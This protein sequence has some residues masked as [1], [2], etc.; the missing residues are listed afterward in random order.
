MVKK[1]ALACTLS[2]L[3]VA[4]LLLVPFT[5]LLVPPDTVP[6]TITGAGAAQY[7]YNNLYAQNT[8]F[9]NHVLSY[10]LSKDVKDVATGD[11]NG[12]GITDVVVATGTQVIIY[13]GKEDGS[14]G[15]T[16][17]VPYTMSDIR[18][19]AVGDLDNDGR[20]DIAATYYDAASSLYRVGLFYQ[21]NG[22][23]STADQHPDT[24]YDPWQVLIGDFTNTGVNSLAVVCRGD[25]AKSELA[26][27][28]IIKSPFIGSTNQRFIE[29]PGLAN[30]KLLAA[31]HANTDGRLDL[32]A[33]DAYGSKVVVLTQPASF[34]GSWSITTV[35]LGGSIADIRFM[36]YSGSGS[37]KDLVVV[38]SGQSYDQVEV[39]VNDGSIPTS[40]S[41]TLTVSGA[42]TVAAGSVTGLSSP[43][44]VV[45]SNSENR[46]QFYPRQGSGLDPN[47]Y[48]KFPVNT[49][50]IKAVAVR[51]GIYVLSSGNSGVVEYYRYADSSM[52][53]ADGV[54]FTAD[55][56][57]TVV[58]AGNVSFGIIAATYD[59]QN[60]VYVSS[61]SGAGSRVITTPS[62]PTNLYIGDLDGDGIGDLAVAFRSSSTISIYRG[63]SNFMTNNDPVTIS[64]P[65]PL[66][67]PRSLTGGHIDDI[68]KDVLVVGCN[69]GIDVIYNPLSASPVH[70]IIGTSNTAA[71]IDVA[72]GRLSPTGASGGIAA[73][74]YSQD[75]IEIYYVK[76]SPTLGHC[77]DA[78]Y[79]AKLST[80]GTAS[81]SIAVG[82]FDGNGKDD[83][84]AALTTN[85][86]KIF[87]NVGFS[88]GT[89]AYTSIT[90]PSVASQ[91]R[92]A[93]LN[94][95]GK[96]DL[97]VS[98]SSQANIGIWLSRDSFS[99]S[100]RFNMTAG[101]IA[102]G[103]FVGDFNGDGRAD[104]L[105]SS[106][107]SSAISYWFQNDL[108]PAASAWL[109]STKVD[110]N[111][112][113]SFDASNSTDSS[114]DRS[115]LSYYWVFGDGNTSRA[116]TAQNLY[117]TPGT[118][119]GYLLVTDRSGLTGRVDF[120]VRVVSLLKASFAVSSYN[121]L[122]GANITV[123]DTSDA[124]N[125]IEFRYWDLGDGRTQGNVE[126]FIVSYRTP[127]SYNITLTVVDQQ[128]KSDSYTRTIRVLQA[129]D[130]VTSIVASGGR[131]TFYMDET[132][133]FEVIVDNASFP[134]LVYAWDMDYNTTSGEFNKANGISI[135]QTTWS[136]SSPGEHTVCVR[137]ESLNEEYQLTI[138]ILN[139][140]P[141]ADIAASTSGPGNFT[142]DASKSWDSAS[143]IGSL[144]YRWNFGDGEGWTDWTTGTRA[145]HNY[146]I[147]GTYTV[148]LE[149]RDQ[150][151]YV[152]S[153]TYLAILD[154][155][156]PTIDLDNSMMVS[157]AYRGE[158]LIIKVNVTDLTGVKEV[159]LI[160]TSNNE[161]KTLAMSR[162]SGTDTFVAT[163]PAKDVTGDLSYYIDA[164]DGD[165]HHSVTAAMTIGLTDRPDYLWTYLVLAAAAMLGAMFL[166]YY[167]RT[168]M[169]VD[170]VFIIYHD[171]N[172]MAHQTRRL[173]PGMDDQILGSMLVAIQDFVRDSFKDEAS[174]GLNRM[175]FGDQKVLVEKGDHIYLA[176]VLHGQRE[177]RVPQ[178]MK[179]AVSR[180]ESN[181]SQALEEWDGDLEKVRGI[182]EETN[183]LLRSN[184]K[185]IVS[186]IPFIGHESP[187]PREVIACPN[188]GASV[189]SGE[190]RCPKCGTDMDKRSPDEEADGT[191]GQAA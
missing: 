88:S 168:S 121:P 13:F 82:D 181:Y 175:D 92:S 39:R 111:S 162:V 136:Y 139:Y 153:T 109:S 149:V 161:T 128:G 56:Q 114:S 81:T 62:V 126:S 174:T 30:L 164:V 141:V 94:D 22:F 16:F 66:S 158:D 25:T 119:A 24:K 118:Y 154:R 86:V 87:N 156:P 152:G 191:G 83:V 53:N 176:V 131:T 71:R 72:F 28:L 182:K 36:D 130:T 31:G 129:A 133:H 100:N 185:D 190:Q 116:R 45:L 99:F 178:R 150:W 44:L 69:G 60:A 117:S 58:C 103:I 169:V 140:R 27:L 74:G 122:F 7:S 64:I 4:L 21:K 147:D 14:L 159:L 76:Q 9:N 73:L 107:T 2:L 12:D 135:N 40:A 77:Y 189:P 134:N 179:E 177:G 132:I 101:G 90:L 11:L 151:K 17:T 26:G 96:D 113:V 51:G 35:D 8:V 93:D 187:G 170:D 91:V 95:D 171:G 105:A 163:I 144:W 41:V 123:T 48:D 79:S 120:Q 80:S 19:L 115:S 15:S 70:E 160:Y 167:R 127:G 47:R 112:M 33:G 97:A 29:L 34:I 173:K 1:N 50:P 78:T 54:R 110:V 84:A 124:P 85:Q 188:C 46:A 6:G 43:D 55:G 137:I 106:S 32:V 138:V 5:L 57:P 166:I 102:S 42:S 89:Q 67:Q 23:S 172:L 37:A 3:A 157:Q 146:T 10:T 143:D 142:F 184:L 186:S 183:P 104:I 52:S 68:G 49:G 145:A 20:D 18:R 165:G 59:G 98:Y 75:Y 61:I 148:T 38:K 65:S 155:S 63:S 125:G 180:A 108:A